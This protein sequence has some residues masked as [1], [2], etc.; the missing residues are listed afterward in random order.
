MQ[1][2][3]RDEFVAETI[4]ALLARLTH[5]REIWSNQETEAI[6]AK[7]QEWNFEMHKDSVEA[8]YYHVW[9]YNFQHSLFLT[10]KLS[11]EEIHA[12]INHGFFENYQF[13]LLEK[14]AKGR[15]TD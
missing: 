1:L 8:S 5:L 6:F 4:P 12:I 9:E 3:V 2:D 15:L 11:E 7:L 14:V 10:T 13:T